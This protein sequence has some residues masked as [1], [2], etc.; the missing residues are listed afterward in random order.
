MILNQRYM[1]F[2]GWTSPS[3]NWA[4][5]FSQLTI[6][7]DD[8]IEPLFLQ[9]ILDSQ[10]KTNERLNKLESQTPESLFS[11]LLPCFFQYF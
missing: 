7:F 4:N 11:K 5:T 1:S 2:T 8:R 9:K 3:P 10:N 6:M